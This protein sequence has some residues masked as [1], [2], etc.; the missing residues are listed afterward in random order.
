MFFYT[1]HCNEKI[2]ALKHLKYKCVFLLTKYSV[3]FVGV[4]IIE[5][6]FQN[7]LVGLSDIFS[8]IRSSDANMFSN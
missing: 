3:C 1:Y 8:E 2:Y 6:A 7:V 5:I 4:N